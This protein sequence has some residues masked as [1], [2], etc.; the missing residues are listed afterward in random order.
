MIHHWIYVYL[1]CYK[2][3]APAL[4]GAIALPVITAYLEHKEAKQ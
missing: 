1:I 4:I 2:A 3:F